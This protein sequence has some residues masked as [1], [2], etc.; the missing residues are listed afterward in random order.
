MVRA[1]SNAPLNP[2]VEKLRAELTAAEFIK[3][4]K[5]EEMHDMHAE[6][7]LTREWGDA[8]YDRALHAETCLEDCERQL[9]ILKGLLPVLGKIAPVPGAPSAIETYFDDGWFKPLSG[10]HLGPAPSMPSRAESSSSS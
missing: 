5:D 3:E 7:I 9:R 10:L 6:L 2:A 4:M 1:K 8:M